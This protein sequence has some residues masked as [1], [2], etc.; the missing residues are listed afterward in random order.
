M[1]REA[2]CAAIHGVTKSGTWLSDWTELN[3]TECWASFHNDYCLLWRNV[4]LDLL[5]IFW[6]N[7]LLVIESYVCLYILEM[8]S[9]T[10]Y[11]KQNYDNNKISGYQMLGEGRKGWVGREQR[12]FK[13]MKAL[14]DTLMVD[15]YHY[16]LSKPIECTTPRVSPTVNHTLGDNDLSV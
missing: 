13:T 14:H 5:V 6:F 10:F 7:C 16:I 2:W 4:Y 9:L 11:K 15:T 8:N 3:L 1:D 12:I